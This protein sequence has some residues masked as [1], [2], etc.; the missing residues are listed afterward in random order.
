MY[1]PEEAEKAGTVQLG[2]DKTQGDLNI[3]Y[4]YLMGQEV[5]FFQWCPAD[6]T[7]GKG[8]KMKYRNFCFT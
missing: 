3:V 5:A 6:R 8:E 1:I 7:R 2:K 4:K